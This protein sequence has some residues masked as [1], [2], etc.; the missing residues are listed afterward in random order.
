MKKLLLF[1]FLCAYTIANAQIV[2]IPDEYFKSIFLQNMTD[3]NAIAF[4]Q[5]GNEIIIDSNSD[6]EIQNTEADAVWEIIFRGDLSYLSG[7]YLE[8][9]SEGIEA[10]TNLRKLTFEN[11]CV[12]SL[13]LTQLT[14]LEEVY[15]NRC[16]IA[17]LDV[18]GLTSLRQL[19]FT[20][21]FTAY[22]PLITLNLTGAVN[23]EVLNCTSNEIQTLDLSNKH[24]LR[25]VNCESNRISSLDLSGLSN[26]RKLNCGSNNITSTLDFTA[27]PLIENIWCSFNNISSIIVE[28]KPNLMFLNCSNNE[29]SNISLMNLPSLEE[30]VIFN[31]NITSIDFSQCTALRGIAV[32]NNPDLSYINTKNGVAETV[33]MAD[34]ISQDNIYICIDEG[35]ESVIVNSTSYNFMTGHL[36]LSTYCSFIPGGNYNT[37]GGV[38]TFDTDRDGCDTEDAI[39]PLVKVTLN[40]NMGRAVTFTENNGTYNFYT[41]SG[42]FVITPQFE[43]NWFT[44]SPASATV[45]L[46]TVDSTLVNTHNFC[47]TS[48]GVH[49]DVEVVIVPIGSARPGFDSTYEVT[50]KNKG[51]QTLSGDVVFTYNEDVLDYVTASAVPSATDTGS[52]TWSYTDLLPFESRVIFAVLNVNGPMEI[53]AINIG[54]LLN[55]TAAITPATGDETPEDNIFNLNEMV[56]GS[57]DPNDITCLEGAIVNPD[58]IGEYLHYNINFENTGTAPATFIVVKDVI[59]ET[60]FDV[61]SLVVLN[62][63]HAL[64]TR[65]T[66]NKVE[67]YFGDINLAAN[68]GKGNVTF[69]IKSLESLAVNSSVMQKADI[70]FDYNWP[71]VT[72]EAVT[73]YAILNAPGFTKD[74]SVKIYPN[75]AKNVVSISAKSAIQ[76]LQLFDVQGRLLEATSVNDIS[77]TLDIASRAKG[78]YFIKIATDEGVNVVKLVKE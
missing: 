40:N 53:P 28:N 73:T 7:S 27:C 71:I 54:D 17:T 35:D 11:I 3:D 72:N 4:D 9:S 18:S 5:F 48:N 50:Y 6:D 39:L 8:R 46:A 21:N 19:E 42:N 51:N 56:V 15:C 1:L 22:I 55:V 75:P 58:K 78:I 33:F 49:P 23:L 31:N 37:I 68:G 47:I 14:H 12:N 24:E 63:S 10:F 43:N 16:R 57:F 67:L 66:G 52:L 77:I 64:E 26:L 36:Q 70:F 44:A 30:F 2:D 13:S 20:S 65:V 38:F 59:D 34:G 45:N 76:T 60:K 62:A 29:L 25:E 61:S 41:Q 32:S 69:K 74:A